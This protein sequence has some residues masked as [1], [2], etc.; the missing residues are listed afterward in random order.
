MTVAFQLLLQKYANR[1][2]LFLKENDF[3][4]KAEQDHSFWV[5]Y[6]KFCI[7][8]NYNS[9]CNE[10]FKL[11]LRNKI[12]ICNNSVYRKK[13]YYKEFNIEKTKKLQSLQWD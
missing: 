3:K 12:L 4:E 10:I 9:L 11:L 1:I 2:E 6:I 5:G 13:Y 7:N 8:T